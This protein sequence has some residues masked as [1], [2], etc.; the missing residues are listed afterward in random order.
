MRQLAFGKTEPHRYA[1][2]FKA[3]GAVLQR[4]PT[5]HSRTLNHCRVLGRAA[6]EYVD[7]LLKKTQFRVHFGQ[8]KEVV[9]WVARRFDDR[10]PIPLNVPKAIRWLDAGCG[11]NAFT[12]EIIARCAA[13]EVTAIDPSEE[14]LAYAA[15]ELTRVVRRG[16]WVA[17]YMWDFP[18]GGSPVYPVNQAI[19][20]LGGDSALPP[21]PLVSRREAMRELWERAGLK[22]VE[23]EV[24][25]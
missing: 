7:I 6:V 9:S 13:A 20:S 4:F 22:S 23:T 2:D 16:G 8:P 19:K 18:G 24:I 14:Q 5:G 11:N 10:R 12:E 15:A 1:A 25:R 17:T 3:N 21:N